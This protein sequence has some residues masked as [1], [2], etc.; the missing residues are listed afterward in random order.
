MYYQA[1]R[2]IYSDYCQVSLEHNETFQ[3]L[4]QSWKITRAIPLEQSSDVL[5]DSNN[6]SFPIFQDF[7]KIFKISSYFD[8]QFT[9]D[10]ED[11]VFSSHKALLALRSCFF[12]A[13]FEFEQ[14]DCIVIKTVS[15]SIFHIVLEYICTDQCS[16]NLENVVEI[17]EAA[18]HY[19]LPYLKLKCTAL[20]SEHLEEAT[21]ISLY[22]KSKVIHCKSL[23][24]ICIDF[25]LKLQILPSRLPEFATVPFSMRNELLLYS[26]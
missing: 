9:F 19:D 13:L 3:K 5:A 7:C 6:S 21:V 2:L 17:L 16:I 26:N 22:E 23:S 12:R 25:M 18:D 24:R 10:G 15:S 20:I 1:L 4:L 14:S 11:I 8:I